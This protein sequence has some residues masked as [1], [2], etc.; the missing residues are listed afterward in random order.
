MSVI[1]QKAE[2]GCDGKWMV[3]ASS[4]GQAFSCISLIGT[5]NAGMMV[6]FD[7]RLR[8]LIKIGSGRDLSEFLSWWRHRPVISSDGKKLTRNQ[9]LVF[10][11]VI[12]RRALK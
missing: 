8:V 10:I 1:R 11:D 2:E 4:F 12:N 3:T 5:E 6:P 9:A 7:L